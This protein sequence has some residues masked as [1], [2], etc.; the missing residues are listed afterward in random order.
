MNSHDLAKIL[1]KLPNLP[2]A[3]HAHNNTYMS[4]TNA[5]SHGPLKIALLKTYGG[6]HI[7]IGD[8]SIKNINPPN[9]YITNVYVGEIPNEH[10]Y[11]RKT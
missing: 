9:W 2:I 8:I 5:R 6:D 7:V 10:W 11:Q 1:L 4:K 3:T